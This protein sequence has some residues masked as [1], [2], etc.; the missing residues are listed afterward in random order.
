MDEFYWFLNN[1]VANVIVGTM[2]PPRP[3][4]SILLDSERLEKYTLKLRRC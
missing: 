2:E 4:L 1:S 3:S